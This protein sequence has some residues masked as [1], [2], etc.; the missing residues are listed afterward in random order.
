MNDIEHYRDWYDMWLLEDE[1]SYH[2]SLLAER[3]RALIYERFWLKKTLEDA[4]LP[5]NIG[6]E[7][8]R[9]ILAKGMRQMRRTIEAERE[10]H[11]RK[12]SRVDV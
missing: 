10:K 4:G 3:E 8:V 11:D 12:L 1:I 9:Q 2:M 7:R 6:K 5:W